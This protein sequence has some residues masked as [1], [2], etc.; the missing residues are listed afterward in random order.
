MDLCDAIMRRQIIRFVYDGHE[1]VVIPEAHGTHKTT[2]NAVLRGYQ[3]RGTSSSRG[4]PL[5]DLF[6]VQK[7]QDVEILEETFRDNPPQYRRGDTHINIRC[8]L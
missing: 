3:I 4:V 2:R 8:E 5:W 1:R 7:M 6:L